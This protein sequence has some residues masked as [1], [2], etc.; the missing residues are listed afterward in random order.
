MFIVMIIMLAGVAVGYFLRDRK[1]LLLK[2]GQWNMTAIYLLLFAMGLSVGGD[3]QVMR[4]LDRLGGQSIVISLCSIGG[5]VFL[6]WVVYICFFRRP[7]KK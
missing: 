5:S 4:Q 6:S 7:V 1:R 2:I 3:E